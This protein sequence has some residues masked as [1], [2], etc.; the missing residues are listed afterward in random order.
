MGHPRRGPPGRRLGCRS[1]GAKWWECW[2]LSSRI[3]VPMRIHRTK[4]YDK[5]QHLSPPVVCGLSSRRFPRIVARGAASTLETSASAGGA[6]DR[7]SARSWL[8]CCNR[9]VT[10][11][12]L[13]TPFRCCR[14]SMRR[15]TPAAGGRYWCML[16][17]YHLE[18]TVMRTQIYLTD[19]QR[20]ILGNQAART[21]RPMSE[22]IREALDEYLR[23]HAQERRQEVL[24]NA[25][26][27]W[28]DRIDREQFD[29]TRAT[30]DR[31]LSP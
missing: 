16:L 21:G 6:S 13:A 15:G 20:D 28:A 23:R 26:G 11:S 14:R 10:A 31:D 4:Q 12:P 3:T 17:M 1:W 24:R 7:Q 25:A 9:T 19:E 18:L 2:D 8:K 30:L 5:P 29:A 22:L 27:L